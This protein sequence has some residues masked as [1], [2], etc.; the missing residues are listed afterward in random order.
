MGL[1]RPVLAA[2]LAQGQ[3]SDR[4]VRFSCQPITPG[5]YCLSSGA[6]AGAT[7]GPSTD[8]P[9]RSFEVSH[10]QNPSP[11]GRPR[12]P[13]PPDA[14]D[15]G[16]SAHSPSRPEDLR[17]AQTSLLPRWRPWRSPP[18]STWENPWSSARA[19]H[20][21]SRRLPRSPPLCGARWGLTPTGSPHAVP[22]P[23]PGSFPCYPVLGIHVMSQITFQRQVCINYE[24]LT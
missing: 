7:G 9:A 24:Q 3:H 10:W 6:G 21:R 15:A 12:R 17:G 23:S 2:S 22:S 1:W 18:G 19:K 11:T 20:C 4:P 8:C 16:T 5:R 14:R 13:G